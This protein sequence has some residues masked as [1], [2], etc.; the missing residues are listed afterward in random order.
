M[1]K[2]I[3]KW[4]KNDTIEGSKIRLSNDQSLR[5]R[6]NANTADIEIAKVN[7]ADKIEFG[8]EV[9]A[10]F[11]PSLPTSLVNKQ[12]VLDVLAGVRDPKDAVRVAT[13][14]ALPA[15]TP[16]GTGEGKTLTADANGALIVDGI[17]VGDGDRIAVMY[18]GIHSGIYTVTQAGDIGSPFI[19]TRST[20]A[21]SDVEVTQG[22]SFDVVEGT[23]NGR[24]RWLLTTP[25]VVVDTTSLTFVEVPTPQSLVQFKTE[26]FTLA[27]GD[28]TNGYVELANNAEAQ[29]LIVFPVGGPV[30][31]DA[32]DF[33][34][35][36]PVA[37]TRVTFAGDLASTLLAGDV[38]VVKYSHF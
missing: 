18:D 35:S 1:S 25:S 31:E 38:L 36:V 7:A 24:T 33:S 5:G 20:D 34:L 22:L 29:S 6:N 3:G 16:A 4:I 19:L 13:A 27:A 15:H 11:V 28:I 2:Q 10:N 26:K 23:A 8:A 14:V 37:V 21:D 17:T 30:Q 9:I 32:V 12:Y